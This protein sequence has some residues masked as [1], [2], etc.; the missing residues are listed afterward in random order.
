MDVSRASEAERPDP[1]WWSAVPDRRFLLLAAALGVAAF[2]ASWALL[3]WLLDYGF[4]GYLVITDVGHYQ[5][6][7][8]A[9][10]GGQLP[11]RDFPLVYPP[12]ALPVFVLPS[13]LGPAGDRAA[14]DANF[15][16][17]MLLC[18]ALATVVVLVAAWQAGW[19]RPR[20][21]LAAGFVAV[22][23]LLIGPVILS[24]FDLWPAVLT[25]AALAAVA[26][27]R[28]RLGSAALAVAVM[29]KVYPWVVV[30]L[31]L[32][33]AWRRSGRREAAACALV[34]L[35]TGLL[36][37][38]PFFLVAP[39]GI[40]QALLDAASRPLQVESLGASL[41]F[42]LHWVAGTP[43]E[44]VTNFGSQNLAGGL[45]DA[46]LVVQSLV[47][48]AVLVAVW[49][50]F[51]RGAADK[52]RF[53]W[54]A[55][56]AVCAYVALGKV[57]SPQYMIW[58][59]PVVP[60]VG[61]RRGLVAAGA[62]A[63]AL[64][65]TV[66]YIP[67]RYFEFVRLEDAGAALVVFLR[68]IVLV[69]LVAVLVLP[70]ESLAKRARA[71]Y[72]AFDQRVPV[73]TLV[74]DAGATLV[75]VLVASF[76]LRT[77]WLNLPAGALIFD[78][79]YYVNVARVL[80]GIHPP[81][82]A[83]Y[84]DATLFLDPEPAHPPL[85]K[86]L[87][88]ASM[89]IFGDNGLGWRVPSVVAGMA[90]LAAVYGIV[91]AAGGKA[92]LAVLAVGL[93]SL[94]ILSFIHGRIGTLDMMFVAFLLIGAWLALRD[95]WLLAGAALALGTLVKIPG[96]YGFAAVFAWQ[97]LALWRTSRQE[98]L[99]W[100]HLV[101]IA[102]LVGAYALV[103]LAVLWLLDLRFTNYP[104]PLD[105]V[106]RMLSYGLALQS[107]F[108][109]SGITS[110]PW[111]WLVNGGQFDYLKTAVNTLVNG[112]ITGSRTI[113][114]FRAL[115]NPVLIGSASLAVLLGGWLAWKRNNALAAWAV[116]WIAANYLPYWALVV[117][118][119]RITYFFYVLPSVPALAILAAIFLTESRLPSFVRWGYVAAALIAFLAYFPFRQ[120]P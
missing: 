46:L 31:L 103:G 47:L 2:D 94:D 78:E 72:R 91:R 51:A 19:P 96:V 67:R 3:N 99:T 109:P 16:A 21:A 62:L 115:M 20:I 66:D 100:A 104:T 85:G 110:A 38:A 6:V 86:V 113:V 75:L 17:L 80:L 64:L 18:G 50:W 44:V 83:H 98:R 35:A 15:E 92:W 40:V 8:D 111:E 4:Y 45:A 61:G 90:A 81:A 89:A 49:V 106:S 71:A 114:Q 55:A 119:H 105:H 10:L 82:G 93:Y 88:A 76:L 95:R 7:G 11:Y 13:L 43:I 63:L 56:A 118:A 68:D 54:A 87:I 26:A 112:E 5:S 101:P 77:L 22:S 52:E 32:A 120:V 39:Q 42:F 28:L 102:G 60:L 12:A 108:S 116:L 58:L 48:V 1:G 29:A 69:T 70:W 25:A 59:I 33:Y 41:L 65:L 24:R 23:P 9:V 53:L 30:P 84:A 117:F 34:G 79:S 73:A 36:I 27:G 97:G 107:G 37:V 14:Y 57:L 74:P